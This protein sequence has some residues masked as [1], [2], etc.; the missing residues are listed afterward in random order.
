MK[1]TP[2]W[3]RRVSTQPQRTTSWSIR[4]S[5][6]RPQRCVRMDGF[7]SRRS[8]AGEREMLRRNVLRC[9]VGV[10]ERAEPERRRT[11]RTQEPLASPGRS[12]RGGCAGCGFNRRSLAGKPETRRTREHGETRGASLRVRCGQPRPR[13][14]PTKLGKPAA[15]NTTRNTKGSA[16]RLRSVRRLRCMGGGSTCPSTNPGAQKETP[17]RRGRFRDAGDCDQRQRRSTMNSAL[18]PLSTQIP[19][20][21]QPQLR[22]STQRVSDNWRLM[23][24]RLPRPVSTWHR[25]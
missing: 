4:A 3:S 2:P 19:P 25:L 22:P 8:G 23:Y 9:N 13:V 12:L 24:T 11:P 7:A 18:Q 5:S 6:T 16:G 15:R 10:W 20:R 21:F 1:I 17:A 14:Q